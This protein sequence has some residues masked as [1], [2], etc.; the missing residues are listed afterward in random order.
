[1]LKN[2]ISTS[3]IVFLSFF[4]TFYSI[5]QQNFNV[6]PKKRSD[7]SDLNP[8]DF[9]NLNI[10]YASYNKNKITFKK[11]PLILFRYNHFGC[12]ICSDS[13]LQVLLRRIKESKVN[14]QILIASNAPN[15]RSFQI[16]E[17][18][19]NKLGV[20]SVAIANIPI[21]YD[22]IGSSYFTLIDNDQKARFFVIPSMSNL[23]SIQDKVTNL[24][25]LYKDQ[26]IVEINK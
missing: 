23:S 20:L 1:M 10:R 21:A 19:M 26:P 24:F 3:I 4:F 16:L 13:S 25:A 22:S 9:S 14:Y 7:L 17:N 2:C 18:R 12:A 15:S 11:N 5:A 6:Q 8:I